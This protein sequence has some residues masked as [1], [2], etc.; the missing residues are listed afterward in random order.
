MDFG[1]RP[2]IIAKCISQEYC[3]WLC[4]ADQVGWANDS[5]AY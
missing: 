2:L 5:C 3:L 1:S 4:L